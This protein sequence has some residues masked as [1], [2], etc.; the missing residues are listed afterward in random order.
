MPRLKTLK[1][2]LTYST[3]M[4]VILC[5]TSSTVTSE[6]V[7]TGS[8]EFQISCASCHGIDG[9]GEGRVASILTVKPTDLTTLAERHGGRFPAM[10]VYKMIDGRETFYAH[11]DRDMPVWGIR[12]LQEHA[13]RYGNLDGEE[14][15]QQRISK[16]V[17][18]IQ[19]IQE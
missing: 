1:A 2:N 18:H 5:S 11:G 19:S 13:V 15:V 7:L 14:A 6:E 3:V 8:D 9:K 4:F 16:L 10:T 17:D 12:Y